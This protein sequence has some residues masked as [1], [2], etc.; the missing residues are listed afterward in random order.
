[1]TEISQQIVLIVEDARVIRKMAV[2]ILNELGY[3]RVLEAVDGEDA[4]KI[5]KEQKQV[6]LIIS[7]W[8]MPNMDG[9]EFLL[10]LKKNDQF[11]TIPF[12]MATAQGE[13]KQMVKAIKAGANTYI[14]KPFT[15]EEL[16]HAI[17]KVYG[18]E[19]DED[20]LIDAQDKENRITPS[21]K[22]RLH[23]A[24]IQ[25]TDHLTLGVLKHL[26]ALGKL[27]P[28]YFE[29]ETHCM[30]GW[31]PVQQALEKGDVDAAF[32]LAPIAMDLFS[33]GSPIRMILLAHKSGSICIKQRKNIS[34][35]SLKDFFRSKSFYIPH[36][37]SIHHMLSNMFIKE[38]GLNP[39]LSSQEHVNLFFEVVPPIKMPDFLAQ[40]ADVAGYMVAEPIGSKAIASNIGDYL[41]Y[42][43]EI[44]D[45]HPC[46]VVAC[47]DEFIN[48]YNDAIQEFTNMLVKAGQYITRFPETSAEI[49]VQFLDPNQ[50]LGLTINTLENV[51]TEKK[52]IQTDD[53]FPVVEDFDRIQKYMIQEM[54]IGTMIDLNKFIDTQFARNACQEIY[55]DSRPSIFY[56][57]PIT[58]S[59]IINRNESNE[60]FMN[61]ALDSKTILDSITSYIDSIHSYIKSDSS[62]HNLF[63]LLSDIT[64]GVSNSIQE[65]KKLSNTNVNQWIDC[66]FETI[67]QMM[68]T[69]PVHNQSKQLNIVSCANPL[70]NQNIGWVSMCD[71][72]QDSFILF[73]NL[74]GPVCDIVRH[75]LFIEKLFYE[76]CSNTKNIHDFFRQSNEY[77]KNISPLMVSFNC[78]YYRINY[79]QNIIEAIRGNTIPS[80]CNAT[81]YM[82]ILSEQHKIEINELNTAHL[83]GKQN[84]NALNTQ[85]FNLKKHDTLFFYSSGLAKGYHLNPET[86]KREYLSLAKIHHWI[87]MNVNEPFETKIHNIWNEMTQFCNKPS[88]DAMIWLGVS[89]P[90]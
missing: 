79:K 28:K 21:G 63:S 52:G 46:C 81:E 38:M 56:P 54:G 88:Q 78:S 57:L 5:L 90:N 67:C 39:G 70:T 11:H 76:T 59:K 44:W 23:V 64:K 74:N 85:Q 47:R 32:I 43:S 89:C 53:L 40:H 60:Q 50:S 68:N 13:R 49:A 36:L 3:S 37:L 73:V 22:V 55:Q 45:Y 27:K 72:D 77:F 84:S 33:A 26:I 41:F 69:T 12:I 17:D 71:K 29:L 61:E 62:S 9:Y 51:L 66:T 42:S 6:D 83:I 14:T 2:N 87:G 31:N 82:I 86:G 19:R 8:N 34:N 7:D 24:H 10:W 75:S 35:Q 18:K 80:L 65:D 25:I 58:V 16:K 1:M 4:I 30:P 15:P 48:T 20:L